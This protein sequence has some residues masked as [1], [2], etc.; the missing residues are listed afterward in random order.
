MAALEGLVDLN[1]LNTKVT[2]AGL[3]ELSG[4]KKLKRLFVSPLL[5]DSVGAAELRKALPELMIH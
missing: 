5:V 4:M 2:E 3:K 1:L